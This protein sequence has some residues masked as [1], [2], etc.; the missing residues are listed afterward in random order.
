[1]GDQHSFWSFFT[2]SQNN[3]G[4]KDLWRSPC[5]TSCSKQVWL[6][7]HIMLL[8]AKS[9]W[10]LKN[11]CWWR[12][13]SLLEPYAP[14]LYQS[15]VE[16]LFLYIQLEYLLLKFASVGSC[17]SFK[18]SLPLSSPQFLTLSRRQQ[19]DFSLV[20][21]SP[22]WI[23]LVWWTPCRSWWPIPQLAGFEVPV[24]GSLLSILTA[25]PR[26]C[27]PQYGTGSLAQGH[28][29]PGLWS[30]CSAVPAPF[31]LWEVPLVG[32][33]LTPPLQTPVSSLLT[34]QDTPPVCILQFVYQNLAKIK[35]SD[36]DTSP[37]SLQKTITLFKPALPWF[38]QL[39]VPSDP[40][41][42]P[43]PGN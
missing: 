16:S 24:V 25:F 32:W 7:N 39:A 20:F 35:T 15:S 9:S 36:T 38:I 3:L 34:L 10:V 6:Q 19:F 30:R 43:V 37:L 18:K 1:M 40:F 13:H 17:P 4:W 41:I 21:S 14:V 31:E 5:P 12:F 22:G 28:C 8:R 33:L 29:H 11:L 23:N 27:H 26:Q 2:A 42:L